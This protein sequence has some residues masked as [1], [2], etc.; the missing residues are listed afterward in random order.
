MTFSP[1]QPPVVRTQAELTAMWQELLSP[2]AG[3]APS[4]SLAF[5]AADTDHPP[6]MVCI[7]HIPQ[8]PEPADGAQLRELV[9]EVRSQVEPD[10]VA[11]AL[12]RD[13][14]ERVEADDRAW[15]R[16]LAEQVGLTE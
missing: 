12:V 3:G 6:A 15:G 5:F 13:G 14:S 10:S 4:L 16:C 1:S 2:T 11:V 9:D 7:D 8:R